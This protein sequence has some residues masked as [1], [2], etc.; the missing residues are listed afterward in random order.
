M[1]KKE[2]VLKAFNNEEVDRV[3]MGFWFHFLQNEGQADCLETPEKLA[4]TLAGH[5]R[6]IDEFQ[7]DFLKIMSDGYFQYPLQGGKRRVESLAD[8]ELIQ[9]VPA[10]HPWIRGQI[11]LVRTIV[12]YSPELLHL[13]NVFSPAQ[14]LKMKLLGVEN[15]PEVID[16][17]EQDAD[18]VAAALMRMAQGIATMVKEVL[19]ATG[20]EGIYLSVGTPNEARCSNELYRRCITP[21]DKLVLAAANSLT[22]NSM[23]HI[24]GW[25]GNRN[26]LRLFTDYEAKVFNWATHVEHIGLSEG[27]AIFGGRA[28][29]GGFP[30][31]T[32]SFLY[33]GKT[34][35]EIK[36]YTRQLIAQNGRK[37]IMIGADC[38]LPMDM[39]FERLGWVRQALIE[40]Q[41]R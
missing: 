19:S 14:A 38:T 7:P 22:S 31:E 32:G 36:D 37:G 8:L 1:T 6:Y 40:L 30:S 41:Q 11:E 23:L 15:G 24:C 39:S 28:V 25:G 10:D 21:S 16:L 9:P 35:Q 26:D 5:K 29:L 18:A 4:Q 17:L 3:P 20:V 2:W 12:G 34:E 33:K 27:K 13:Y